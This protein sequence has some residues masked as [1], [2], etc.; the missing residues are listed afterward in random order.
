MAEQT[1]NNPLSG[2]EIIEA[3]TDSLRIKMR[4]DC[5]LNKNSAY[6]WFSGDVAVKLDMHDAGTRV[7]ADHA[8][9]SERGTAP[10]PDDDRQHVEAQ[11]FIDP[12]PPNEVRV[13]TGQPVP[14]LTRDAQG[15]D[16]IK[17]VRYARKDAAKAGKVLA[18]ILACAAL[19]VGQA[20][21]PAL[22]STEM[23]ALNAIIER[24]ANL[25]R[26][27]QKVDAA[28]REIEADIAKGHPGYHFDETKQVLAKDEPTKKDVK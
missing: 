13:G 4:R 25:A 8:A 3:V 14:T 2:D 7:S 15:K 10:N 11:F 9:H 21:A 28:L 24:R 20:N 23:I 18:L 1:L 12:A 22:T 19:A 17:G 16:V 26:E 27:E 5:F 6:D